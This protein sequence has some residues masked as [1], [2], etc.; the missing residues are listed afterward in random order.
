MPTDAEITAYRDA[1]RS[2][3]RGLVNSEEKARIG[4]MCARLDAMYPGVSIAD[5]ELSGD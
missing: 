3:S 5:L 2:V 1:Q 4:R